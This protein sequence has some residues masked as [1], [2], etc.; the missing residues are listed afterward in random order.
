M[1]TE[2]RKPLIVISYAH[3]DEPEKP[4]EGEV[5]W[6]SFVSGY[7]RPAIKQ[8]A[9]DLWIDRLMP[10]GADWE[11]EIEQKLRACDIFILLVS[12]HSLSS[13]YIAAK[14]VAIIRERQARREKVHFYP[15]VLTP[16][17]K[18]ALDLVKDKNLRPR[19]GKPLSDFVIPERYR[20]MS[21]IADEIADIAGRVQP[22][23]AAPNDKSSSESVTIEPGRSEVS[24]SVFICYRRDDAPG[25]AGRIYDRLVSRLG[26]KRVFFDIHIRPGLD[27][28]KIVKE[29]VSECD[30][31]LA[32]LGKTWLTTVDEQNQRRVG[33][34]ATRRIWCGL[35]LRPR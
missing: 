6:L 9:V 26:R 32:V 10:G 1:P 35:K 16:T 19:D 30:V 3:V 7:L 28:L 17:P 13:N 12:P 31:L 33:A 22:K 25:F 8:G 5:K 21:D 18:I 4:A 27:F 15:V 34:S 14:E 20:Q 24:R 23:S 29:Q 11:G 2:S